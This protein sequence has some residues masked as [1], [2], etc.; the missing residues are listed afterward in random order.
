[1]PTDR[2]EQQSDEE[3]RQAQAL[4]LT[5]TRPP[6]DIPG[7]ES[8]RFLGSGAYG[9]VWVAVDQKTGRQVAIK[10]YTHRGG[11]DWSLLSREVEKL[12]FL[13]ADRY[14]VQ[15]LD[16]GWDSNPPYYVMEYVENGSLDDLLREEGPLPVREAVALFREVAVGLVHAHGKGVLHCDLK[17]ANVLLDQDHKP[18]LADFGQSRLSHEQRPALGTLFYMAPEQADMS[19]MPDARWDVYALGALLYSMLTGNPPYRNGEATAHV[20]SA[21]DL[22]DRLARYRAFLR[23]SLPPSGHRKVRGID[24]ALTEIVDR[25]LAVDPE[26]RFANVQ[27]VLDALET[28][29]RTRARLP[30]VI[31]GFVGPA[32]LLAVMA[33]FGWSVYDASVQ[34][35][36]AGLTAKA[37]ESNHFAAQ[38]VAGN[39]AAEIDEYFTAV[40]EVAADPR[41]VELVAEVLDDPQLSSALAELGDPSRSESDLNDTREAFVAH[42]KRQPLQQRIDALMT[43][44]AKPLAASWFVTDASGTH[45]AAVFDTAP[46]RSPVGRNFAWRTYFHGGKEDLDENQRPAPLGETRLSR[47]LQSTATNTWKVAVSTPV[48]RDG[49]LLG[50]V[51]LTMEMGAFVEFNNTPQQFAVLIDGREGE[52]KGVILQHPLFDSILN[53]RADLPLRFSDYRVVVDDWG[54]EKLPRYHDPLGGDT[55]GKAY[56]KDWVAAKANVYLERGPRGAAGRRPSVDTGLVVVVQEDHDAVLD[57]MHRLGTQLTTLGLAA[58]GVVAAVVTV[59]W[60]FVVRLLGEVTSPAPRPPSRRSPGTSVHTQDTVPAPRNKSA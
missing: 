49:R 46:S 15:L 41:F 11:L 12:V 37:M 16:V 8:Q 54:G 21:D 39:V 10:F 33:I 17:P 58:L 28:R 3:R 51:A 14:V 36:D 1:M 47:L 50:I 23:K 13:A 7:Y 9:E 29:E 60:Y 6:T 2:T 52:H 48:R 45:L 42:A 27:E 34:Q 43:D 57:P 18:R 35:T 19:A 59:Q 25:C 56:A 31:L 24:R 30:L 55:E 20:D 44:R 40:E 4:S 38:G 53:R 22:D 32:L 26:Q 5:R